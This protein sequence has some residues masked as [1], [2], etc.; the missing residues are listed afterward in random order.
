[1]SGALNCKNYIFN[2]TTFY[3]RHGNSEYPLK[4]ALCQRD[5]VVNYV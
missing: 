3:I 1:M 4:L 5:S 2:H